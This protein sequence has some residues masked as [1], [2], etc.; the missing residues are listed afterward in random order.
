MKIRKPGKAATRHA[1]DAQ[2]P[3]DKDF[4]H[5][6]VAPHEAEP[7]YVGAP[8]IE[9]GKLLT[10]EESAQ[11]QKTINKRDTTSTVRLVLMLNLASFMAAV[12]YAF[13]AAPNHLV[14]GGA[15]GLSI[16]LSSLIPGLSQ[17]I[18]LWAVNIVCVTVGLFFLDRKT[19]I[20]SMVSSLA[21]S[22][23][24]T[25]LQGVFSVQGSL[26]GDLWI[27]LLCTV[28]LTAVA[29]AMAFS[30]GT[31]T[32]GMDIIISAVAKH[33]TLTPGNATMVINA[34]TVL[35]GIALYGLRTGLYCVVGLLIVT[36]VVN[37][38]LDTMKQHK[39]VTVICKHPA[40][41]EEFIVREL[42]RTA[43]IS[44]AYGAY[45][46][47]TV[48]PIMTVLNPRETLKLEQYVRSVDPNA[49]ITYVNT[50]QIT[51]KGFRLV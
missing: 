34:A 9:A 7:A 23:Y 13:F 1:G 43:T 51:G 18:A 32:G 12:S 47:N 2:A 39:I 44:Q 29:A 37:Y 48:T 15:S 4:S 31:T 6:E 38:V 26:T 8:V 16:L 36:M 17:S 46:G 11:S 20:W 45:S 40:M 19:V 14:I 49:F 27:D 30:V 3:M 35:G 21:I 42:Y 5:V 24:A 25:L 28:I 22:A 50:S 33:T 41:V 10:P